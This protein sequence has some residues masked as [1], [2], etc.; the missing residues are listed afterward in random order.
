[1]SELEHI[2]DKSVYDKIIKENKLVAIDFFATWCGPC[3]YIS[4][5]F[6]EMKEKFP[7]IK[8]I[9]VDVDEAEEISQ[10]EQIDCMPTFIFYENGIKKSKFSGAD[11]DGLINELIKLC[12]NSPMAL[13]N[14]EPENL[15]HLEKEEDF[16]KIISDNEVV[17]VDYF[18]E[19]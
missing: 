18:A 15:I 2:K 9:K 12:P 11:E 7:E 17:I 4:P 1:M 14:K 8:F 16:D 3:Q 5:I 13:E 10:S 6:A 19:W